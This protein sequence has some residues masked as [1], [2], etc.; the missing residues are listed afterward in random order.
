MQNKKKGPRLGKV[1]RINPTMITR[2]IGDRCDPP[3][4]FTVVYQVL[5]ATGQ[6]IVF[7]LLSGQGV[8]VIPGMARF[9][10]SRQR[11]NKGLYVW[12]ISSWF[13]TKVTN[14]LN[15]FLPPTKEEGVAYQKQQYAKAVE[16]FTQLKR[17]Q[18]EKRPKKETL[19]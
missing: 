4:P 12:A 2:A 17:E 14:L 1:P 15:Q 8:V 3:V 9:K 5:I 16:A 7:R 10:L 6:E 18:S 19:G 13:G 11:G